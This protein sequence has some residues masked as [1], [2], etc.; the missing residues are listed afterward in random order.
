[1]D[2][3]GLSAWIIVLG[4]LLQGEGFALVTSAIVGWLSAP[5]PSTPFIILG[6]LVVG[7]AFVAIGLLISV[8]NKRDTLLTRAAVVDIA[9][10]P[11]FL[12][13]LFFR[14]TPHHEI[15]TY[16]SGIV[17]LLGAALSILSFFGV[18][19]RWLKFGCLVAALGI[20]TGGVFL[21][22]ALGSFLMEFL[23]HLP[24]FLWF[25]LR[26]PLDL[27]RYLFSRL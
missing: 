19:R 2:H 4:F 8:A 11:L 27:L 23:P 12:F 16:A 24:F 17:L 5:D 18:H 25:F 9:L 13:F 22:K 14:Y 20:I 26:F 21:D 3:E 1:M 6:P 7:F 15:G 10:L